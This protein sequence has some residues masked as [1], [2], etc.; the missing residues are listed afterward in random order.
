MKRFFWSLGLAVTLLGVLVG[1]QACGIG[2]SVAELTAPFTCADGTV[3]TGRSLYTQPGGERNTSVT[4]HC[5]T[6]DGDTAE[7][8]EPVLLV[9][10]FYTWLLS[11]TLVLGT[12]RLRSGSVRRGE[13]EGAGTEEGD[14]GDGDGAIRL[15]E[16]E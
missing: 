5:R 7:I 9:E 11:M 4:Y 8:T 6:A 16:R 12:V 3:V 2:E 14:G 1:L 13:P 10:L 15:A